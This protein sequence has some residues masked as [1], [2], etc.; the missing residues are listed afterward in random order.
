M[1]RY[2][3]RCADAGY[4]CSYEVEGNSHEEI[5]PKR[6]IHARYAHNLFEINDDQMKKF[7]EAI[8]EKKS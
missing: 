6:R 3:F 2:I 5:I 7:Q 8:K 4:Q 1:T